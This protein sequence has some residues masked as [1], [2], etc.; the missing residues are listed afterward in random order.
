M[1]HKYNIDDKVIATEGS[2]GTITSIN[3][4]GAMPKYKVWNGE[5]A[6]WYYEAQLKKV[7]EPIDVLRYGEVLTDDEFEKRIVDDSGWDLVRVDYI[8]IRT[9]CY[10]S[11]IYYMK[12]V[13]GEVIEFK[14]LN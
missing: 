2:E 14:E 6:I 13:D 4:L 7:V 1:E 10:E 5:R 9:I 3:L 8:R 11:A 12:M